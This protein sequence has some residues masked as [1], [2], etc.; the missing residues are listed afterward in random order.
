MI[1]LEICEPK[2]FGYPNW[3]IKMLKYMRYLRSINK[4]YFD[5]FRQFYPI[6]KYFLSI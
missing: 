5:H 1:R 6:K 2:N 4:E 3:S